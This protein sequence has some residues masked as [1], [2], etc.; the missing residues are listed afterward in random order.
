MEMEYRRMGKIVIGGS[1]S[2][3]GIGCNQGAVI[4]VHTYVENHPAAWN[5]FGALLNKCLELRIRGGIIK[6]DRDHVCVPCWY[7]SHSPAGNIGGRSQVAQSISGVGG[8]ILR[9]G[10]DSGSK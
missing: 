3:G 7:T 2:I 10:D 1:K 5:F 9:I 8:I 4:E 6:I